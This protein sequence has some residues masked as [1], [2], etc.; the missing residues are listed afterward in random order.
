MVTWTVEVRAPGAGG[1]WTLVTPNTDLKFEQDLNQVQWLTV[2]LPLLSVGEEALVVEGNDVRALAAGA[3]RWYGQIRK[4]NEDPYLRTWAVRA[5]GK[6]VLAED[7]N[8]TSRR[9]WVNLPPGV[10]A[11]EVLGNVMD[12]ELRAGQVYWSD[13]E[14]LNL[15]G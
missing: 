13:L 2:N 10:I 3:E 12:E 1:A 6:E 7:R 9:E 11:D 5:L 4:V 14:A 8:W 15:D